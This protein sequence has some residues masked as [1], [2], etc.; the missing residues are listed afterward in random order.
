MCFESLHFLEHPPT[1]TLVCLLNG[2]STS[3]N[4]SDPC[5]SALRA[6]QGKVRRCMSL[7]PSLMSFSG[8][9]G[10]P[11][12]MA[13][14]CICRRGERLGGTRCKRRCRVNPNYCGRCSFNRCWCLC[15]GCGPSSLGSS[16]VDDDDRQPAHDV[17]ALVCD[18]SQACSHKPRLSLESLVLVPYVASAAVN[19]SL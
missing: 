13:G 16:D 11:R 7:S 12:L 8:D 10:A 2:S 1:E 15:G 19:A 3:N 5:R 17:C 4:T 14:R 9:S 6:S 18:F